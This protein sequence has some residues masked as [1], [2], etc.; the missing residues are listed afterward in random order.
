MTIPLWEWLGAHSALITAVCALGLTT[1]QATTTRRH[2]R[3][4]VRPHLTTFSERHLVDGVLNYSVTLSNNGLGPAFVEKYELLVDG[5]PV[6]ADDPAELLKVVADKLAV[7]LYPTANYLAILRKDYVMG[8]DEERK[9]AD[10]KFLI[11]LS[12]DVDALAKN[13]RRTQVR[14]AYRSAYGEKFTYDSRTHLA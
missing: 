9:I 2:N 12:T 11:D 3:V 7:T 4:S 13:L 6:T 1:Y 10:V 5:E 8:K 14:L